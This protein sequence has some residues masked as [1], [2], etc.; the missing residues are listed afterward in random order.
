MAAADLLVVSGVCALLA[1]A[2]TLA[3][4]L[5]M[6]EGSGRHGIGLVI[7]ALVLVTAA[8]GFALAAADDVAALAVRA[9][10]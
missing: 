4:S 1:V 10:R 7:V 6:R 5:L 9:A 8:A 3:G 2:A